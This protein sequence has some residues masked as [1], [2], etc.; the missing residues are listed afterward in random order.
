MDS[1][2]IIN[3][4]SNKILLHKTFTNNDT[5]EIIDTFIFNYQNNYNNL[6]NKGPFILIKEYTVLSKSISSSSSILFISISHIINDI[7]ITEHITILNNL[8]TALSLNIKLSSEEIIKNNTNI[9]L[10][11][12]SY[13]I[14]GIPIFSEPSILA[15]IFNPVDIT[16]EISETLIGR[17]KKYSTDV[18]ENYINDYQV[19]HIPFSHS[20]SNNFF[21]NSNRLLIDINEY[22]TNSIFD[23]QFNQIYLNLILCICA[24]NQ[25]SSIRKANLSLNLPFGIDFFLFSKD[26]LTSKED[27]LKGY[28]FEAMLQYGVNELVNISPL[29]NT[30]LVLPFKINVKTKDDLFK[31]EIILQFEIEEERSFSI[32]DFKLSILQHGNQNNSILNTNKGETEYVS[33]K[34]N[35]CSE[36]I[37][38]F[39]KIEK[40]E[41]PYLKVS[42]NKRK[43]D[44]LLKDYIS[45][46]CT[47]TNYSVTKSKVNKLKI[48]GRDDEK[49]L[50]KGA[51]NKVYFNNVQ[52]K[53]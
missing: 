36:I 39:E 42:F 30:K 17:P 12:D 6:Y 27:F 48:I 43:E 15:S 24:N 34:E 25:S 50:Y 20:F 44:F 18:F 13:L 51:V 35:E 11:I 23:N 19:S 41:F 32:E 33:D 22:I 52:I 21:N 26:V 5:S 53:I 7:S 47:L 16:D 2:Y 37:W 29:Y 31:S 38:S 10:L 40:S 9:L 4:K 3:S 45:F 46:D 14:N 28:S 8:I 1:L 49:S